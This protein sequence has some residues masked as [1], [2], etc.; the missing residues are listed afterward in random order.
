[1]ASNSDM[2]SDGLRLTWPKFFQYHTNFSD[3][4]TGLSDGP[5]ATATERPP[6][7]KPATYNG[8]PLECLGKAQ[9]LSDS[10]IRLLDLL[11]GPPGTTLQ[12]QLRKVSLSDHPVY[13]P[14]SY[15]WA[16][17]PTD[18]AKPDASNVT[19]PDECDVLYLE[20]EEQFISIGRNCAIALQRIRE[21]EQIKTIWVDAICINQDDEAEKKQQIGRMDKIY[22]WPL[23]VIVYV[24]HQSREHASHEA[25]QQLKYP[26]R[27]KAGTLDQYEVTNINHLISRPYFKRM[28]VVQECV[29]AKS[30][31]LI[32]GP[33]EV[34]ISN[35]GRTTLE[36]L[37][38]PQIIARPDWLK[39][40]RQT[41]AEE[42]ATP[43]KRLYDL[44][45]DT[46]PSDC[47]NAR[48]R[49][50]AFL[51]L[52]HYS[53]KSKSSSNNEELKADYTLSVGH[54]YCGTAA[55]LVANGFLGSV[56]ILASDTNHPRPR[57]CPRSWV[58]DW[59]VLTTDAGQR[60]RRH[61]DEGKTHTIWDT[62]LRHVSA[63]KPEKPANS[64]SAADPLQK[65]HIPKLWDNGVLTIKGF[66]LGDVISRKKQSTDVSHPARAVS[67]DPCEVGI[68]VRHHITRPRLAV[69]VPARDLSV[70][71]VLE[72]EDATVTI[73]SSKK[74]IVPRN[75]VLINALTTLRKPEPRLEAHSMRR[76]VKMSTYLDRWP[77]SQ[78][79]PDNH[80]EPE[81]LHFALSL[82]LSDSERHAYRHLL[83]QQLVELTPW[84]K[85]W[86]RSLED[87]NPM[88]RLSAKGIDLICEDSSRETRMLW[89]KWKYQAIH[90]CSI[91][92]DEA[93]IQGVLEEIERDGPIGTFWDPPWSNARYLGDAQGDFG[94]LIFAS[95]LS[96][97]ITDPRETT[98]KIKLPELLPPHQS[99]PLPPFLNSNLKEDATEETSSLRHLMA[100][101]DTTFT[102]FTEF[103]GEG[104]R[105]TTTAWPELDHSEMS[106]PWTEACHAIHYQKRIAERRGLSPTPHAMFLLGQ[107]S[108]KLDRRIDPSSKG[109]PIEGEKYW[110]WTEFIHDLDSSILA[111]NPPAGDVEKVRKVR[112]SMDDETWK[113]FMEKLD[114]IDKFAK[115]GLNLV[116]PEFQSFNLV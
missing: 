6:V 69:C 65:S 46:A 22:N 95:F 59:S 36:V 45:L 87:R 83:P 53:E 25:M 112:K 58:P 30:L 75:Y 71:V 37:E 102:L 82:P 68:R 108:G 39:H 111:W 13:E 96:L 57:R 19:T 20:R 66:L 98:P 24:G 49:I 11:P 18:V 32:C 78:S 76:R 86:T 73:P 84:P 10:E 21:T 85:L 7:P 62:Y 47:G 64:E 90:G 38:G 28:W 42:Q 16:D 80:S 74:G 4:G 77:K 17:H 50:F 88:P 115:R 67:F 81:Y 70:I 103:D 89:H 41:L 105:R 44:L 15:T 26:M 116:D 5:S 79:R 55:F 48:D 114:L 61:S 43:A 97:F 100:W 106:E 54:V 91:L 110:D 9:Y 35:F 109:K 51:S 93:Q 101:A 63:S 1:M 99:L 40:S 34:F 94:G 14:L 56:L 3:T 107:I 29:L 92:D 27:L 23:T 52:L 113:K 12:G 72:E 8:I 104:G 31:R 2:A 60:L 33:D